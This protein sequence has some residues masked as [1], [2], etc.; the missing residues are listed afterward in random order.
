MIGPF[1]H[2]KPGGHEIFPNFEFL[3]RSGVI[4]YENGFRLAYLSGK[5]HDLYESASLV[6]KILLKFFRYLNKRKKPK[7]LNI[8]AIIL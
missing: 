4:Q 7:K 8:Q 6:R 3:G 1:M 2:T 5:D